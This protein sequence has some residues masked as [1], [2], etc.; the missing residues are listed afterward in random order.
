[1]SIA[2]IH[3]TQVHY[4]ALG[5]GQ[6]VIFIHGWLGSWRYWWPS[7]QGLS[8]QRRSFALDLWGFGDS[9]NLSHL[10]SLDSYVNLLDEFIQELAISVPI[11]IVGHALGGAVALRYANQKPENVERLV[12]VSLPV[13]KNS[14]N[15]RLDR[16]SPDSLMKKV[17][18]KGQEYPEIA[19]EIH[20]TDQMA[21]ARLA[22]EIQ[23]HDFTEELIRTPR[24]TLMVYGRRDS[25]ITAPNENGLWPANTNGRHHVV[26]LDQCTHFPMLEAVPTF[27]R[28][29]LDFMHAGDD[30][31][32]I[33]PKVYWQRRVR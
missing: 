22:N 2:T 33:T 9:A 27:N 11:T 30:I 20:K 21:L 4:E 16:M 18:G 28:L 8:A 25:V 3:H 14:L 7:M 29:L 24:P 26:V 6:P 32:H 31:D 5:R 19:T 13:D 1:M 10:Y 12:A 17:L 23:D 15:Q